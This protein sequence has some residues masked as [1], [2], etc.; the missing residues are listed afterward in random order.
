MVLFISHIQQKIQHESKYWC[1]SIQVAN[2][3][4]EDYVEL[5]ARPPV[6]LEEEH[7]QSTVEAA[8]SET[9]TADE[10]RNSR[11]FSSIDIEN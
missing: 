8:A 4:E 1:D 7:S 10:G 2:S 3:T 9:V 11:L 5:S 6:A